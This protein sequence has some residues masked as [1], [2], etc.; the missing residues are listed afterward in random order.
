MTLFEIRSSHR[1]RRGRAVREDGGV[2]D[3]EQVLR[4]ARLTDGP[5][6]VAV[7]GRAEGQC[8]GRLRRIEPHG[9][10]GMKGGVGELDRE[11]AAVER[12]RAVVGARGIV[13][14]DPEIDDAARLEYEVAVFAA[15]Q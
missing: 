14:G 9:D 8:R 15:G 5:D 10:V 12:E 1:L 13:A 2:G 3:D 4:H 11:R 7:A 6:G